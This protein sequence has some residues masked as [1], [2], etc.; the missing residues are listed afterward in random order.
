MSDEK[1]GYIKHYELVRCKH[2]H[3]SHYINSQPSNLASFLLLSSLRMGS[4]RYP[5]TSYHSCSITPRH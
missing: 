3:S 2:I 1:W 4:K 5:E